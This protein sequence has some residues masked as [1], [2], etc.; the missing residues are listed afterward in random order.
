MS[1]VSFLAV[2]I[3][4]EVFCQDEVLEEAKLQK[5]YITQLYERLMIQ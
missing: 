1:H 3:A 2:G 4:D 5:P